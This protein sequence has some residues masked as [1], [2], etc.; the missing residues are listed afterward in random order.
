MRFRSAENRRIRQVE[1]FGAKFDRHSLK[2]LEAL[3]QRE[4][5]VVRAVGSN[6]RQG[7]AQIPERE[8]RSLAERCGI[9][10]FVDRLRVSLLGPVRKGAN[11]GGLGRRQRRRTCGI[12]GDAVRTLQQLLN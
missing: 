5:D 2:G 3:E 11:L 9:E 1:S 7:P 12:G 4:V 6:P 10:P 8:G